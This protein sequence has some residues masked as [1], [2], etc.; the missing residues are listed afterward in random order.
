M[1]SCVAVE[2][3]RGHSRRRGGRWEGFEVLHRRGIGATPEKG[4]SV[5]ARLEIKAGAMR[6]VGDAD[7]LSLK[8]ADQRNHVIRATL[9]LDR[10]VYPVL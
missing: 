8:D 3:R 7:R 6:P 2:A 1:C 9:L 10:H 4:S 5:A